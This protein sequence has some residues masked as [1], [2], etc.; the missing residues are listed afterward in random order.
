MLT[1]G[2]Y[3]WFVVFGVNCVGVRYL[4]D[5]FSVAIVSKAHHIALKSVTDYKL[6]QISN[7]QLPKP[8]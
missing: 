4:N 7:L 3:G 8:G 2:Y 5:L 6:W 1:P